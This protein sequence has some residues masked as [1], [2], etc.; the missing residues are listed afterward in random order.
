MYTCCVCVCVQITRLR[1]FLQS[2]R[3]R[4]ETMNLTL[5]DT[6]SFF[7]FFFLTFLSSCSKRREVSHLRY[8][9]VRDMYNERVH[10]I[11]VHTDVTRAVF[12]TN[13]VLVRVF[14]VVCCVHV[15]QNRT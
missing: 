2:L 3:G 11:T 9:N 15:L 7:F 12:Y 14:C 1:E 6:F 13:P 10:T 8:D 5:S 4:Y